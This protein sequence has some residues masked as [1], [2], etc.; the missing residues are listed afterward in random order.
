M[1]VGVC[2]CERPSVLLVLASARRSSSEQVI[3]MVHKKN[4][5]LFLSPASAPVSEPLRDA[6]G[7]P[8]KDGGRTAH[9]VAIGI[10]RVLEQPFQDFALVIRAQPP[11][12][13]PR[14]GRGTHIDALF[15]A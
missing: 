11:G 5:F 12:S 3:H 15:L 2:V 14:S 13:K 4:V 8:R 7:W 1:V 9:D 6:V 10:V